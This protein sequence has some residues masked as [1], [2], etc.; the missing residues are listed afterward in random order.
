MGDEDKTVLDGNE[1]V[2]ESETTF[3][4]ATIYDASVKGDEKNPAD[5]FREYD[6]V[7]KGVY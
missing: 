7:S 3:F 5:V 6:E 1:T 2:Y 4:D